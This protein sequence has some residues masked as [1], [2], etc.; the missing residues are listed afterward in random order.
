MNI[1]TRYP[2]FLRSSIH[3]PRINI[4]VDDNI[5]SGIYKIYLH[6]NYGGSESN[7]YHKSSLGESSLIFKGHID[8]LKDLNYLIDKY[9]KYESI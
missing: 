6:R 2:Y 5:E 3:I 9:L 4:R 8:S 7:V 1:S